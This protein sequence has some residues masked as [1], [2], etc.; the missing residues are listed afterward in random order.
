MNTIQQIFELNVITFFFIIIYKMPNKIIFLTCLK[1]KV[2]KHSTP[3]WGR[4]TP[5]FYKYATELKGLEPRDENCTCI[6]VDTFV[7]SMSSKV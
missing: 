7:K 6:N 2:S 1:F 5:T 3:P 4:G